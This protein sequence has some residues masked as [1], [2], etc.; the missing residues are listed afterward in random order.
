MREGNKRQRR[1]YRKRR[2]KGT[3]LVIKSTKEPYKW[4][5]I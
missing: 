4:V 1:K 3:N 2:M 5:F